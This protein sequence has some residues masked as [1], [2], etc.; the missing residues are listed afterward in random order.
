M[1]T[2][3]NEFVNIAPAPSGAILLGGSGFQR[4]GLGVHCHEAEVRS[5]GPVRGRIRNAGDAR[6]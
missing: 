1:G 6:V 5:H 3:G 2:F 4:P